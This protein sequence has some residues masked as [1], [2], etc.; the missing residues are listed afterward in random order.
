[1]GRL[2]SMAKSVT[3]THI[4][5]LLIAVGLFMNWTELHKMTRSMRGIDVDLTQPIDIN[6][7]NAV[8]VNTQH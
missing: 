8:D 4:L 6:L 7:P 2:L 3:L 1:M 5:L